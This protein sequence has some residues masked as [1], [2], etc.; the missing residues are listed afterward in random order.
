MTF[1]PKVL[2]GTGNKQGVCRGPYDRLLKYIFYSFGN[3]YISVRKV[4]IS[5]LKKVTFVKS[6]CFKIIDRNV[7]DMKFLHWNE[8]VVGQ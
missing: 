7:S 2:P 8:K 4:R 6:A 3:L 5:R 1:L